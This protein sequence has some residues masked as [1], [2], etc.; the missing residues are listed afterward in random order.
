M[1]PRDVLA[2]TAMVK[3]LMLY[4]CIYGLGAGVADEAGKTARL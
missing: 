3:G 1:P 2:V 4:E